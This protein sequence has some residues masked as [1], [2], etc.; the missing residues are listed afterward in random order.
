MTSSQVWLP[1]RFDVEALVE[2]VRRFFSTFQNSYSFFAL[3]AN[4]DGFRPTNGE[5]AVSERPLIDRWV[6]S[7]LH[8]LIDEAEK[9][10]AE[11]DITGA[12]RAIADFTVDD[13]SNWYVRRSR[14]RFWGSADDRDKAAAYQTLFE[15]LLAICKLMAPVAPFLSEDIYRRLTEN[16]EGFAESVHLCDFPQAGD[17]FRSKRIEDEREMA[18]KIVEIG[19][20]ARKDSKIRVRQPLRRL[21][22]LGLS[23]PER[24]MLKKM[25]SI[26]LDEINVKKLEYDKDEAAYFTVKAEPDFKNIGPKFGVKANEIAGAI[27]ALGRDEISK[28]VGEG[29][30]GISTGDGH[31]HVLESGDVKVRV[32]AG[33]GFSVCGDGRLKVALDLSLDDNLV[34]EGNARELVNK[35]QNLRKTAGLEVT[36]RIILGI[37]SNPETDR[38]LRGF[39]DYIK[40]ETLTEKIV[41]RPEFEKTNEFDLNG[42]K[43]IIALERVA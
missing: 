41:E 36:D 6:I 35:I 31:R 14:R 26:V 22:A 4:I 2:V 7:R 20:A 28:F 38:A 18:R 43:T 42:C 30:L 23:D 32:T 8:S 27:K 16:L 9:G 3:Y 17:S 21:V 19:R 10:Y 39:S 11:N 12:G 34:A 13:L 25:E 37:S 24:E 5:P 33:K 29:R 15:C 40:N 1:K